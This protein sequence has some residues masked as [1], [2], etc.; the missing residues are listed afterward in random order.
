VTGRQKAPFDLH[1][2]SSGVLFQV[3]RAA[4]DRMS[5]AASDRAGKQNDALVALLFSA[6]TLESLIMEFALVAEIVGEEPMKGAAAIITEA[7]KAHGSAQLKFLL[8]KLALTG[9]TYAKGAPPYQDFA[10]LFDIRNAIVHLKP[11]EW[12]PDPHKLVA[13]LRS[14]KLCEESPPPHKAHG[15][16]AQ[17]STRAVARWGCN[18]AVSMADSL[19]ASLPQDD[20]R[21]MFSSIFK[22]LQTPL[23]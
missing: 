10:L 21:L 16:I 18:V 1:I 15:W 14:K 11:E 9:E 20:R 22:K 8:A 13:G 6:A 12:S 7:E 17:I 2:L 23:A 4:Y 19:Y 3:A 5:S